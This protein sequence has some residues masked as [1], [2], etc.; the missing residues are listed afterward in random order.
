MPSAHRLRLAPRR[1][2]WAGILLLGLAAPAQAQRI[3]LAA[4]LMQFKEAVTWEAVSADGRGIRPGWQQQ[5]GATGSWKQV[6][7][8]ALQLEANMGWQA[9]QGS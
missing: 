7:R 8:L 2:W 9:V 4:A 1:L 6:G 3:P 5:A